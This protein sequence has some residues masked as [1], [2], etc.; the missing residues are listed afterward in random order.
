LYAC[1]QPLLIRQ[2]RSRYRELADEV[3]DVVQDAFAKLWSSRGIDGQSLEIREA[4]KWVYRVVSNAMIDLARV[5]RSRPTVTLLE[6]AV[7]PSPVEMVSGHETELPMDLSAPSPD[8]L[9][10]ADELESDIEKRRLAVISA[11]EEVNPVHRTLL[12][13]F[14]VNGLSYVELAELTG[15]SKSALGT[16]LLRARR[17]V[18]KIAQE[19]IAGDSQPR[20]RVIE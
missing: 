3:E 12:V 9:E 4:G 15:I 1:E 2:F 10:A 8:D 16:T 17:N 14:Y 18:L 6:E 11:L 13:E 19:I 7:S 5:R 20:L